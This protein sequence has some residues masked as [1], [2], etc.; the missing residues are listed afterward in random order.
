MKSK[1][2]LLLT[3]FIF[4]FAFSFCKKKGTEI[5]YQFNIKIKDY[6]N[7]TP[8]ENVSVSIYSKSINSG[9]FSNTYSLG[10]SE[11]TESN[12]IAQLS[13]KFGALE[14]IKI[15]TEH[16][17]YFKTSTLYN[18]DDFSTENENNIEISLKQKGH[19]K[20]RVRNAFPFD[21]YDKLIL[22]TLNS[23]CSECVKFTSLS[24]EDVAVDTTLSGQVVN[25]RFYKYQYIITKNGSTI[26]HIDS[27]LCDQDTTLIEINY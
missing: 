1:S 11:K 6:Y 15:D 24:F 12:G 17:D 4:L 18:P 8:V 2:T 21:A 9:T 19:L 10:G 23:D 14:S 22:N 26:S 13:L 3:G 5:E 16:S 27:T 7:Q 25:N 20:I